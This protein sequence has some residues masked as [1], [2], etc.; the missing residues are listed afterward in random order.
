MSESAI[1]AR[2]LEKHFGAVSAL[3][4]VDLEVE[5]GSVHAILGPNGAGKTTLLRILSGLSHA[6]RGEVEI[7]TNASPACAPRHARAFVGY[8]GHATLLYPELTASENLV[9]VGRLYGIEKPEVRASQ[10]LREEGLEDVQHRKAGTFSRGMAQ[11]LSIARALVHDPRLVF[12]DEPFTGLDGPSRS[13]LAERLETLRD[14]GRT[15]VL[16]THDLRIASRLAQ[17]AHFL[18]RG[19]IVHRAKNDE[20]AAH[21]LESSYREW[22]EGN[23]SGE[24]SV[25]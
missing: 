16:I 25:P 18:L 14:E 9:F 21:R 12:L 15:L 10:L 4:G 24:R 6:T 3:R 23:G 19:E 1:R 2:G 17:T 11:R 20:V 7:K 22:I 13:R 8:V 5:Q